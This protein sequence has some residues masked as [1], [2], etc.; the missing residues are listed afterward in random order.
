MQG[1]PYVA[2]QCPDNL[3]CCSHVVHDYAEIVDRRPEQIGRENDREVV[4]GHVVL[5]ELRHS[6]T[7]GLVGETGLRPHRG[8]T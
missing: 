6:T 4:L 2:D 7:Y 3:D 8:L 1:K 5:L